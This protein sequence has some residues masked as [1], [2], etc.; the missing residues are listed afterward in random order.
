[1]HSEWRIT[2]QYIGDEKIFQ[3]YRLRDVTA[4]DHSGNREYTGEI[5]RSEEEAQALLSEVN[6]NEVSGS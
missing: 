5:A 3:V 1:M 6:K 2:S 4:V